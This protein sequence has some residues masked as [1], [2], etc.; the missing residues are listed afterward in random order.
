[1]GKS[2]TGKDTIYSRLLSDERLGFS[3]IIPSTTRPRRSGEENGREYYFFDM[4]EY[5]EMLAETP[6]RIIESR[7]Y[8]TVHGPWYYFTLAYEDI[9]PKEH[10][11]IY[12]ATISAY[13]GLRKYYGEKYVKPIYLYIEDAGERLSRALARERA[14]DE[15]K[16]AEM[17]RRF[18]GDEEDFSK[19]NIDRA[20]I[21]AENMFE[22]KDIEITSERIAGWILG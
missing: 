19:E 22:N 8:D 16:Y 18:L 6:E 13:V 2:A 20:G 21:K 10:D 14:Q 5:E 17:C 11:Y 15:P 4:T 1:M 7:R 3:P 12:I 9:D